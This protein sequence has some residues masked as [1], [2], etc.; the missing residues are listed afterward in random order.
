MPMRPVELRLNARDLAHDDL[1]ESFLVHAK[2]PLLTH[3][4]AEFGQCLMQERR[5]PRGELSR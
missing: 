1:S 5:D 2:G 4:T 3:L